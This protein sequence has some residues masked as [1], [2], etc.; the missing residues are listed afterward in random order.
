LGGEAMKVKVTVY[1]NVARECRFCGVPVTQDPAIREGLNWVADVPG[2]QEDKTRCATNPTWHDGGLANYDGW[3]PGQPLVRVFTTTV[4]YA[5]PKPASQIAEFMFAYFNAD[6]GQGCA[7]TDEYRARKLR[8]L[9]VGDVVQ[10]GDEWLA[11]ASMGFTEVVD[12]IR[13]LSEWP[14]TTHTVILH[15]AAVT[16]PITKEL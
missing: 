3:K 16:M 12:G 14:E 4:E 9:S 13:V 8:S 6:A 10:V 15:E 2:T 5:Q 1:H 7:L 11:C